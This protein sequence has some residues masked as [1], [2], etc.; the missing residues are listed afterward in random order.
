MKHI[1][2]VASAIASSPDARAT[3]PILQAL[4]GVNIETIG[5]LFIV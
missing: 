4:Y 2:R 1:T 5:G 3:C